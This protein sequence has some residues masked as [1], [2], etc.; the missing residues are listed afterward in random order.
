MHRARLQKSQK[1]FEPKKRSKVTTMAPPKLAEASQSS[2]LT[3]VQI[4]SRG[5]LEENEQKQPEFIDIEKIQSLEMIPLQTTPILEEFK[6]PTPEGTS[7]QIPTKVPY[8]QNQGTKTL[9]G[10][11]LEHTEVASKVN[12]TTPNPEVVV[13]PNESQKTISEHPIGETAEDVSDWS[14]WLMEEKSEAVGTLS[15]PSQ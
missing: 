15:Q 14:E 9:K 5:L 12:V 2:R 1:L 11:Q 6:Q 13:E 10:T 3:R 7:R 4:R 8:P